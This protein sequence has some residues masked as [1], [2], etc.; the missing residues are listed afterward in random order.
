MPRNLVQRCFVLRSL[1][2][3][4][5]R[6]LSKMLRFKS[7]CMVFAEDMGDLESK[8]FQKHLNGARLTLR[9]RVIRRKIILESECSSPKLD[10]QR[11]KTLPIHACPTTLLLTSLF[12]AQGLIQTCLKDTFS[13]VLHITLALVPFTFSFA[14]LSRKKRK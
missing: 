12:S 5:M 6:V 7:I 10:W 9:G 11:V 4:I 13:I 2:S 8:C 1:Y 14:I 3:G